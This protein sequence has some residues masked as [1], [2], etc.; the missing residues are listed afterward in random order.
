MDSTTAQQIGDG[1]DTTA[2]LTDRRVR[3]LAHLLPVLELERNKNA[4][5]TGRD[6]NPY[7][8]KLLTIRAV[9]HVAI[10]SG[11][12][13][14]S[15]V[16]RE[17]VLELLAAE[18]GRCAPDR[19]GEERAEV[20][21]WLLDSLLNHTGDLVSHAVDYVDVTAGHEHRTLQVRL[22]YE[23]LADDGA[24]ILV[25]VDPAAVHLLISALDRNL[26]DAQVAFDA[27]LAVQIETGRLDDAVASAQQALRVS[28]THRTQLR[29]FLRS[30]EQ[31][32]R[33]VDWDGAVERVLRDALTHITGRV[34]FERELLDH[35]RSGVLADD[36]SERN[37][38]EVRRRAGQ[39]HRL[40]SECLQTNAELQADLIGA[41]ERFR[42]EQARQAFSAPADIGVV[43]L[44][45]EVLVPLLQMPAASAGALAERLLAAFTGVA[46]PTLPA[47]G[48]L[49]DALVRAPAVS[50]TA[51]RPAV[52]ELEEL[53]NA[54][55]RFDERHDA[56][57]DSLLDGL[58]VP[59]RL[60]RLLARIE[61]DIDDDT[62]AYEVSLLTAL[63]ALRCFNPDG[64]DPGAWCATDDGA[65]VSTV[66]ITDA[67]DLLL[68]PPAPATQ[69][70][71]DDVLAG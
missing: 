3:A 4:G 20:A 61:A 31:N 46:A 1:T 65:R 58:T 59:T 10:E 14:Q 55:S 71:D 41:R 26:A 13:G 48:P 16:P 36:D 32:L 63:T 28:R 70:H 21:R 9:D 27:V 2:V 11:M 15:G 17:G 24:T 7:D 47:F 64:P 33:T 54:F 35:A 30:A 66:F 5:G 52:V 38:V 23:T 39:L 69:E 40:M 34:R 67:A 19:G 60:S 42:D 18:A 51:D 49:V 43:E 57:L 44:A 56:A 6:W 45:D 29:D 62:F 50:E 8:V 22:L 37:T 12:H 25:N 68:H 53:D